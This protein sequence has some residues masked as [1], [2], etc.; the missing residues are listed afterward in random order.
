MK[1]SQLL[2]SPN[3]SS[4]TLDAGDIALMATPS[5]VDGRQI[6]RNT[7]Y[8]RFLVDPS[9]DGIVIKYAASQLRGEFNSCI[10]NVSESNSV[11]QTQNWEAYA[12]A[13]EGSPDLV[14]IHLTHP[15][16][17][18]GITTNDDRGVEVLRLDGD[19]LSSEPTIRVNANGFISEEFIS[20][21][22][23]LRK[24]DPIYSI[25][26]E[27][28]QIEQTLIDLGKQT[29]AGEFRNVVARA[30]EGVPGGF[31]IDEHSGAQ[32]AD[33]RAEEILPPHGIK[34][35]SLKSYPT[36]PRILVGKVGS[37]DGVL[38]DNDAPLNVWQEAGEQLEVPLSFLSE[39]KQMQSLLSQL[40]QSC[41]DYFTEAAK[42][43]DPLPAELYLPLVFESDAPAYL[44]LDEVDIDYYL[45]RDHFDN[46][47]EK[48]SVQFGG[49]T[50]EE[51]LYPISLPVNSVIKKAE[52]EITANFAGVLTLDSDSQLTDNVNRSTG[53]RV[54]PTLQVSRKIT[55]SSATTIDT[56]AISVLPLSD[57]VELTIQ[58]V[59]NA[60]NGPN[61]VVLGQSKV[62]LSAGENIKMQQWIV[63]TLDKTILLDAKDYWLQVT[64]Q[65]GGLMWLGGGTAADVLISALPAN[66]ASAS[67]RKLN[68]LGLLYE[69]HFSEGGQSIGSAL[70]VTVGGVM[71]ELISAEGSKLTYSFALAL[72]QSLAAEGPVTSSGE[73]ALSFSSA[74]AGSITV[75]QPSIEFEGVD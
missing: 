37:A 63:A 75:N 44:N 33:V 55:P 22:F 56:I 1:I 18:F 45:V 73:S 11:Y 65:E 48:E 60:N 19:A 8:L 51:Q 9:A 46:S 4:S 39:E 27:M 41:D 53:V 26:G 69:L 20:Q 67:A 5:E 57:L 30:G 36:G 68:Q 25:F 66:G 16:R 23:A 31:Q 72:E 40:Q 24:V 32:S 21:D 50:V 6:Y 54:T 7:Y 71:A 13:G 17:L 28:V 49:K 52:V 43:N 12:E 35:I 38:V 42:N 10:R 14:K 15:W 64:T 74:S 2:V 70:E 47:D 58:I 29:V 61:G 3:Q 62:E 34:H 59:E